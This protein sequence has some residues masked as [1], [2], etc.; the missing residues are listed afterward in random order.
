[1]LRGKIFWKLFLTYAGLAIICMVAFGFFVS[2]YFENYYVER[3]AASLKSEAIIRNM[4][5]L[6]A[7]LGSLLALGIGFLVARTVTKPLR[8]MTKI[9]LDMAR[10]NF[11]RKLRVDSK[12][13]IGQLADALNRMS[14]EL[15][16][17]IRTITKDRDEILAILSSIVEGVVAVDK[18]ERVILFNSAS[19]NIFSLS[20]DKVIGEF[21]WEIL[22]NNELNSLLKEA[23]SKG[24]LFSRDLTLLFPQERI[25]E[26][27]AVPLGDKEKVWGAVAVL[28]DITGIKK[29]EKMRVEFVANVS[30]ELRTPLTSI[31]GFVET[32]KEG[33][34][35]DPEAKVRFLKIIEKHADRLNSLINDLLHLSRIE[36]QEIKME[37]QSINFKELIDEV[38]SNFR[39]KIE[40]KA[41]TIEVNIPPNF[42]HLTA[43]SERIERVLGNLLDNAIKFTPE[44]GKICFTALNN[45][46]NIRIEVSDTGIGI[47]RE[48]LSRLFERFYR[49]DKARSR[50]LGG[51]GLGL[52]IVKH[53]VRAHGG[54]VGVESEPGKGSK[55]FFTLPITQHLST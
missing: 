43:D 11:T 20:Q 9:S 21:C 5:F 28:H 53:I 13:E 38:V 36:S 30:H 16:N 4:M 49:V 55:F 19:E 17:R 8:E 33:A 50:E 10:G 15:K 52:A 44:G 48:H 45:N 51:T 31:R 23:L 41:L 54:T 22:R 35:D 47:P 42:P 1:M 25:F 32:L 6:G 46:G 26:V 37:F 24:E 14:K 18:E 29:L 12:D 34:I 7:V 40:R 3:I 2:I 39:K 27:H